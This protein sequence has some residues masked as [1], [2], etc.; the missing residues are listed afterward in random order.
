[1]KTVYIKVSELWVG[2]VNR[3]YFSLRG[4][5]EP[6]IFSSKETIF[7]WNQRS[8]C[9]TEILLYLVML[10]FYSKSISF[11]EINGCLNSPKVTPIGGSLLRNVLF[12]DIRLSLL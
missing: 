9:I 4:D 2:T 5:F 3:G 12:L 8:Y 1:M 11:I 10:L 7:L 6:Q